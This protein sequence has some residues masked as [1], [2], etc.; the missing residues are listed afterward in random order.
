MCGLAGFVDFSG[1]SDREVLVAMADAVAHRGPDDSGYEMFRRGEAAVGLGFRRLSIIDLSVLGH[2]PMQNPGTGDWIIFNGEIYNFR[3]IRKELESLNHTFLSSSD[4]EVILKSYEQWGIRCIDKFIGM[5]AIVLYD[6]RRGKIICVRDR[7]GVKPFFYYFRDHLF[8]FGSELKSFHRHPGFRKQ[9]DNNALAYF[10]QHG[11]ISSPASIFIDTFQLP[12]GCYLELD[13]S[14]KQLTTT[15][16]W[17]VIALYNRPES[18]LSYDEILSETERLFRSAF[19]YR[20][21]SDVPV[22]VFLS[23]GY[24]SSCVAALLQ[25]NSS[26]KIKTYTIG[27]EEK[28]FNEAPFAG[29]VAKY[30]GSDHH[31]YYCSFRDAMEFVPR[32][33]D[34]YDQPFGDSSAV[35]TSLI[36]SIARRHVTVALSAD[37]GDELFAGYPRHRKSFN[38]IRRFNAVP[39]SV[40]HILSH[41][42][43]G[44]NGSLL[45]ANRRDKLRR[46]LRS[47]TESGMFDIINQAFSAGEIGSLLKGEFRE[48]SNPFTDSRKLADSVS[49]LNKILAV[50]YNTYLVDDILQ[51]VDRASMAASLEAREPFLDQ[52]LI[53]FFST[54]PARYKMD[55]NNQK[56]ILRDIVHKYIPRELMDRPK[57]GFGIPLHNWCRKELKELFM[58][59]MSDEALAGNEYLI[60][61]NIVALRDGYLR[62]EL[63]NFERIWFIFVFQMWYRRWM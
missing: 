37:G 24:D 61:R 21:V 13:L 25:K 62:G 26:T 60:A 7:A 45:H 39:L 5:F 20:M 31:E 28:S 1:G 30:I 43:G 42:V 53:E 27:F 29:E 16:Y 49:V 17:D 10:F 34:I 41:F 58:E 38:Y 63:K 44:T 18:N 14:T 50:D 9:I 46:I 55:E 33:A 11:Y 19:Q 59:Y 47:D 22:G 6:N 36:S 48:T 3:E 8:L 56:I 52:R 32:L 23:G 12:P 35:P 40:R 15:R 4:T 57:M 2:Q 54:V 51:K